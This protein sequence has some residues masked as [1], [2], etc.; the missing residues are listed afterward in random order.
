[1]AG[2]VVAFSAPAFAAGPKLPTIT[3]SQVTF[4]I[5]SP[6]TSTW[7]LRLWSHGALQGSDNDTSGTLT[8][9]VPATSDCAFQADVTVLPVG[10]VRFFY[11]GV[12]TTVPGCG[13]VTQTIAGDI[14]LCTAAGAQTT[15]EEAGGTL[16]TTGP[17]TLSQ[18]NPIGPAKVPSGTY[19][20]TAT[21][22]SGFELVAC[23]GSATVGTSGNTATQQVTVP[24]GGQGVGIFYVAVPIP[25][26]SLGGGS[27]PPGGL[28][29]GNGPP[30]SPGTSGPKATITRRSV[31]SVT[32][33]GSP[34]LALTG[35]DI[36]PLV[37]AGL[38]ALLLGTLATVTSRVRR[39]TVVVDRAISRRRR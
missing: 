15:T 1:M 22:P 7:T 33:V 30:T 34:K 5:P 21:P 26:G 18:P 13:P 6:G 35:L 19:T 16:S 2:A 8:V 14:F 3:A 20:M 29:S 24:A 9:A 31:P 37:L 17:Q 25:A 10:G 11:S 32:K 12:R 27:G 28:G 38:L 39:R 4:T 23:G 36:G